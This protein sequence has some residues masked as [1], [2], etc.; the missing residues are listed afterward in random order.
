ME[1]E[2]P[3]LRLFKEPSCFLVRESSV[4]AP[5]YLRATERVELQWLMEVTEEACPIPRSKLSSSYR[6]ILFASLIWHAR[7]MN[8]TAF[9]FFTPFGKAISAPSRSTNSFSES[10]SWGVLPTS[11]S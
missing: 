11:I 9:A 8:S 4:G 3:L 2:F 6:L 7:L 10:T 5:E 1:R